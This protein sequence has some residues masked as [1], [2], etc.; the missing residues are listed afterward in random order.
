MNDNVASQPRAFPGSLAASLLV[1]F[2]LWTGFV[3]LGSQNPG[4][5][6]EPSVSLVVRLAAVWLAAGLFWWLSRRGQ[7]DSND[8]NSG[9]D[10]FGF[11]HRIHI[12]VLLGIVVAAVYV[13]VAWN[14]PFQTG[15]RNMPTDLMGWVRGLLIP[16]GD[17][18]LFRAVVAV[19]IYR[20]SQQS[21]GAK[22]WDSWTAALIL[23]AFLFAA[24]QLPDLI[25]VE[26]L[27]L[28]QLFIALLKQMGAGI[29]FAILF[30]ATKSIWASLLPHWAYALLPF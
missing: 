11:V 6:I 19:Q 21:D 30:L 24:I 7:V 25:W 28:P 4:W 1:C 8:S 10:L 13:G 5:P 16:L 15:F 22:G 2:G 18:M 17:E 9:A 26:R 23:S 29:V 12:G 27:E 20:I 14:D 3:W